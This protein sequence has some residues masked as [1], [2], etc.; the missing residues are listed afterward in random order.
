MVVP[1]SLAAI[2]LAEVDSHVTIP[3]RAGY[4]GQLHGS[5]AGSFYPPPAPIGSSEE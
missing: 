5:V 2:V 4:S 3:L 1:D